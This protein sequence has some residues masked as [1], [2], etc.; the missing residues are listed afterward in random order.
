MCL[1]SINKSANFL[2]DKAGWSAEECV[3]FKPSYSGDIVLETLIISAQ[4]GGLRE[5]HASVVPPI[6]FTVTALWG[7]G[8]RPLKELL[9]HCV[10]SIRCRTGAGTRPEALHL[11]RLCFAEGPT[12]FLFTVHK[13]P[14]QSIQR[15]KNTCSLW[16]SGCKSSNNL[17]PQRGFGVQLEVSLSNRRG[18][19]R[20]WPCR[21]MPLLMRYWTNDFHRW[22]GV[23]FLTGKFIRCPKPWLSDVLR[24]NN[25][26]RNYLRS[27]QKRQTKNNFTQKL[28]PS[29]A[30][31]TIKIII[32]MTSVMKIWS[33]MKTNRVN[34]FELLR[35]TDI[36]IGI[37]LRPQ[38]EAHPAAP[39]TE[40]N[41]TEGF[42]QH[43]L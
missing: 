23:L 38:D 39:I 35:F 11:S 19:W 4:A 30:W 43:I 15:Q 12:S 21:S 27:V 6:S 41:P 36:V 7:G 22:W 18:W 5:H 25:G 31:L 17:G 32:S 14:F 28:Y 8:V 29:S 26:T 33:Q 10:I 2:Q 42:F 37:L 34:I 24:E 40:V 9:P 16:T 1:T 13:E 20:R 3:R